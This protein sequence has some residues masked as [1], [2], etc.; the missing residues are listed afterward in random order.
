MPNIWYIWHTKHQNSPFIRCF[1]SYKICNMLHYPHKFATVRIY[2][3]YAFIIFFSSFS[4]ISSSVSPSN[5][6]PLLSLTPILSSQTPTLTTLPRRRRHWRSL[7]RRSFSSN[8]FSF[9]FFFFFFFWQWFDGWVGQW[10]GLDGDVWV[11][12]MLDGFDSDGGGWVRMG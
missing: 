6:N 3:A 12:I 2:V 4:L 11:Q 7:P 8:G 1:K 10:V 9:F 5:P